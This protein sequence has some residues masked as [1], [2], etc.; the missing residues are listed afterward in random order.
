M[1]HQSPIQ[2]ADL[3]RAGLLAAEHQILAERAL[4][5]PWPSA[6]LAPIPPGA[7]WQGDEDPAP[8]LYPLGRWGNR[9]ADLRQDSDFLLTEMAARTRNCGN[10]GMPRPPTANVCRIGAARPE[11][12]CGW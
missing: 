4:M 12:R 3:R 6:L 7:R 10:S 9:V 5:E 2:L 8:Q 1:I 11:P